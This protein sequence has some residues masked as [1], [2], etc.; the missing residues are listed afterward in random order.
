MTKK[1]KKRENSAATSKNEK[2]IPLITR[3]LLSV[4]YEETGDNQTNSDLSYIQE[5]P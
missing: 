4:R 5:G 1:N 3:L 2:K